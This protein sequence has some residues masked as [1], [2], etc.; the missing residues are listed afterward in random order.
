MGSGSGFGI[1]FA[2]IIFIERQCVIPLPPPPLHRYVHD[3]VWF[4]FNREQLA[5]L[6][7]ALFFR[8]PRSLPYYR[9]GVME[10][11]GDPPKKSRC[12]NTLRSVPLIRQ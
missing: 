12:I 5:A 11:T 10:E 9:R 1:A 2:G 4:G 6:R 8:L 7:A 3:L